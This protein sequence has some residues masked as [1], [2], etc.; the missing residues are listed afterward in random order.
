MVTKSSL[1]LWLGNKVY[2]RYSADASNHFLQFFLSESSWGLS[3]EI[4]AIVYKLNNFSNIILTFNGYI[5]IISVERKRFSVLCIKLYASKI[6]KITENVIPKLRRNILARVSIEDVANLAGV[7]ITTVSRVINNKN[8]PVSEKIKKKVQQ[9]VQELGYVPD[10]FAQNLRQ[11]FSNI[12]GLITRDISDPY[13]GTV[14]RAVT[15]QANYYGV[16]S[17]VCN[18]GRD[19]FNEL[20]Y[21]DLLWQHKVR[22]IILA[23]GG[24]DSDDY[25]SKLIEQINRYANHGNRII[26][27]APQGFDTPYVMIDNRSVGE[28]ITDY[29]IKLGHRR[30]AFVSG[31]EKVFTAVERLDGYK[32][33]LIKHGLVFEDSLVAYSNFSWEGGYESTQALLQKNIPFTGLCCANDNIAFGALH[34]LKEH[35]INV[36]EQVSVISVGDLPMA[37]Y[38]SPPLTTVHVPLYEMGVKAVDM[39]MGKEPLDEKSNVI[40]KTSLIERQSVSNI[41]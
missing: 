24:F 4:L 23:G 36:P 9:A 11:N 39:I 27:L 21:H 25:R 32:L 10:R 13:F 18:T 37:E 19:P 41:K 31:P 40:F 20:Q 38:M 3:G 22:G 2:H 15:E 35:G 28:M 6:P 14:A 30:I 16:M 1:P 34:A 26:A 7:S 8:H 33:S 12:I 5:G 29:L 17:F